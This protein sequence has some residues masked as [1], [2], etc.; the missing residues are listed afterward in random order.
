MGRHTFPHVLRNGPGA[1]SVLEI[2]LRKRPLE[3]CVEKSL[4]EKSFFKVI[5]NFIKQIYKK[6]NK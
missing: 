4:K 2:H 5:K 3:T 6:I 1:F